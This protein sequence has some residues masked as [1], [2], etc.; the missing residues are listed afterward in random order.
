MLKEQFDLTGKKAMITG[1]G[2][3]IGA[4][5]AKALAEFGADVALCDL[6]IESCG[7]T[8]KDVET[9]GV[10]A[11]CLEID[12]TS[13]ASVTQ[14][15]KKATE[16]L[17]QIDILCN[18]AGIN[19]RVPLMDYPEEQWDRVIDVNLKGMF[20]VSQAVAPQMVERGWG[21]IINMSSIMGRITYFNQAAYCSSKGGVD[22][23]TKVMALE[24]AK[25]GV[26]V[27]AI[28]PTYI[29]TPLVEQVLKDEPERVDFI[30]KR[31]PMGRLG[32]LEELMGITVFLACP[33]S[34]LITGQSI[35]VDGGWTAW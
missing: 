29:K 8:S 28:S 11:A 18:T 15:V 24:W 22:Q 27:N 32:T 31:T 12:I 4:T 19:Y 2:G 13:K 17:G 5:Q 21:K 35:C 14:A 3:G 30:N 10:Q 25:S 26:R 6:D 9:F 34:D 7:K 33:A 23:L 20:L 16:A 1:A